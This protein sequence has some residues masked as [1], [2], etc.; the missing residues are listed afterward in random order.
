[1]LYGGGLKSIICVI[2]KF[3]RFLWETNITESDYSTAIPQSI[4]QRRK[5]YSGFSE[6]EITMILDEIDQNTT[7]GKRDYAIIMIATKTG[8]R[9]VDIVNLKFENIDWRTKEIRI[10]QRKTGNPLSLPLE[11]D[12]GNA[13]AS[14]ILH[15]RPDS[16]SQVIFGYIKSGKKLKAKS[17]VALVGRLVS[18]CGLSN[19][20]IR[21]GIH[22]FRRGFGK[23]L[24]ES[25]VSIDM[26]SELLGH[27]DINSSK[28][29]IAI[30]EAGLKCCSLSLAGIAEVSKC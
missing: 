5:V 24:L 23:G 13:I 12:V 2:R 11:P 7:V 28:P 3:L 16:E 18:R 25:N 9:A 30:D 14:Y 6:T 27:T 29:Y 10:I 1:M 4:P 17:L 19:T 26:I 8:L 21:C 22:S 15:A 20:R